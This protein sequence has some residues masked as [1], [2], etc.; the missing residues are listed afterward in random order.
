MPEAIQNGD[1]LTN[2]NL[3]LSITTDIFVLN[4]VYIVIYGSLSPYNII[5]GDFC[6]FVGVRVSSQYRKSFL[7]VIFCPFL[8]SVGRTCGTRITKITP[9]SRSLHF[10]QLV[11]LSFKYKPYKPTSSIISNHQIYR[12][13]QRQWLY[14]PQTKNTKIKLLNT[15]LPK[16]VH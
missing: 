4:F 9:K 12:T 2:V 6:C 15:Q 11:A 8:L 1:K 7:S 13:K 14:T 3:H 16:L 5:F 10:I